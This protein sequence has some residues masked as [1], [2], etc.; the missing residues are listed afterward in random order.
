[1]IR[2]QTAAGF[3]TAID[4]LEPSSAALIYEDWTR[5]E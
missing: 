4:L 2:G 3:P 5:Y 1:V